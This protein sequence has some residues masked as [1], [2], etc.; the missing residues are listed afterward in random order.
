MEHSHELL[1]LEAPQLV[2][3]LHRNSK[4]EPSALASL[5]DTSESEDSGPHDNRPVLAQTCRTRNVVDR[6]RTFYPGTVF[7]PGTRPFCWEGATRRTVSL[8]RTGVPKPQRYDSILTSHLS[9]AIMG[10]MKK[11]RKATTLRLEEQDIKALETLKQY[12]GIRSD[13]QAILLAIQLIARQ[14]EE[15]RASSPAPK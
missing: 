9:R 15:G 4:G 3:S 12:Y 7:L 14:I 10:G 13:N 11:Q 5:T 8:Q 1:G 2:S 6:P